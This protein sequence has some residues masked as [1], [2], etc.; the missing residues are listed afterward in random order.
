MMPLPHAFWL[1]ACPFNLL[2]LELL[3]DSCEILK[4]QLPTIRDGSQCNILAKV[5]QIHFW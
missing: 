1:E 2:S 5:I 4:C 3:S